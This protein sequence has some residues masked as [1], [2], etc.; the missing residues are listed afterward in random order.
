[1]PSSSKA[2]ARAMRAAC[3][4]AET[5]KAMGISQEKACEWMRADQKRGTDDLP[6]KESGSESSG[7]GLASVKA[8][9]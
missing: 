2:Q 1:M 3:H 6:E 7:G 4:D 5:A 9:G 8:D